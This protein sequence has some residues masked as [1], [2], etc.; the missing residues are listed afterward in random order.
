MSANTLT[1]SHYVKLL[2]S[3]RKT[4]LQE[5]ALIIAGSLLIAFSAQISIPLQPV[6]ITFQSTTVLLVGVLFGPWRGSAVVA[7]YLLEGAIGMP[8]FASFSA[9]LAVFLH[10]S[11]GYLLGMLPAAFMTGYLTQK[12][13]TRNILTSFVAVTLGDMLIFAAG[14]AMLAY[15]MGIQNAIIYGLLPFAVTE[16]VKLAALA[17][18]VSKIKAAK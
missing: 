11:A 17:V 4:C 1:F 14:L 16:L 12:G 9:G 6:P 13:W 8:V 18:F 2:W 5:I 15:F 3:A 7:L 10:P